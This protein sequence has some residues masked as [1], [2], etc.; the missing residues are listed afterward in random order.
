MH[1]FLMNK[2]VVNILLAILSLFFWIIFPPIL[3]LIPRPIKMFWIRLVLCFV[4][5]LGIWMGAEGCFYLERRYR[6]NQDRIESIIGVELSEYRVVDYDERKINTHMT[7]GYEMMKTLEFKEISSQSFYDK[8]DSLCQEDTNLWKNEECEYKYSG[9]VK[10]HIAKGNKQA[11][12]TYCDIEYHFNS[13]NPKEEGQYVNDR[14]VPG[15]ITSPRIT[16]MDICK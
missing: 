10:L 8:L 12:L 9:N 11:I 5:P 6:Y 3:L 14:P 4:S 7:L 15:F 13:C 2:L 16:S 1:W